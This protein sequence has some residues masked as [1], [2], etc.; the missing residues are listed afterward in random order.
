MTAFKPGAPSAAP[1]AP[2]PKHIRPSFTRSQEPIIEI[3][4]RVC[5]D[6]EAMAIRVAIESFAEGLRESGLGEDE[7]GKALTA[8]YLRSIEELR[9][10]MLR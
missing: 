1:R 2:R 4:G 7:M 10:K 5:T 9:K 6:G 3:N 8:G